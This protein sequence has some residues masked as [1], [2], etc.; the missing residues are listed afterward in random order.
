ME[1]SPLRLIKRCAEYVSI[2]DI[3]SMR[4]GL[5]GIYVLYDNDDVVYVGMTTGGRGG[6]RARLKRHRA[7]KANLWTHCSV[8]EVW[9][10]I[11]DEEIAELE[12]L[13]RHIYRHDSVA[14]KLNAQRGFK[15]MRA[16]TDND[17][18]NWATGDDDA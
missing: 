3:N 2:D 17:I 1:Q 18:A 13:F 12:G 7:K 4:K 8:F 9:D 5:R 15:L 11:R 16:V 14:N 10:N 6:I